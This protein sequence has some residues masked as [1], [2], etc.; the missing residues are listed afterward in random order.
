M[1]T[2]EI[3]CPAK[4]NLFLLVGEFNENKKLH[5]INS[6]NQTIDLYD[7]I[8]I[9]KSKFSDI[10][11]ITNDNIPINNTNSEYIA[12]E[13]FR[14][15]TNIPLDNIKISINR[16]IPNTSGLGGKSTDAA[17]ILLGLNRYYNDPLSKHELIYLA[18]KIGHDVP[19]FIIGGYAEVKGCGEK[20]IPL[21]ENNPYK[22]YLIIK[23]N[24]SMSTKEMLK[25]LDS[26][27][28]EKTIY[29]PEILHNDFMDIMPEELK[30]LREFI[31][32]NYPQLQHSLSSSG[33]AYYIASKTPILP[34]IKKEI[35]KNFPNYKLYE[36]Q[37]CNHHK[38]LTKIL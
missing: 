33:P 29:Q 19:Y 30:K 16:N 12:C 22:H 13:K 25:K 4:I 18:S 37:N 38:V 32:A 28:L 14:E 20:I 11:I 26:I 10:S 3:S 1:R 23:P 36:Q 31:L 8:I 7:K 6:I 15:Y 2:V 5:N 17:G 27:K 24:F 21:T 34:H 9:E 35:L